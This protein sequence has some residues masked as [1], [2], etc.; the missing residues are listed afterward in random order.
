MP[1]DPADHCMAL[2]READPDRYLANLYLPPAARRAA[3]T[4]HAFDSEIAR[5]PFL[6]SEPLPGE[7]RLQWWRDFLNGRT[8]DAVNHPIASELNYAIVEHDWPR[9]V[10]D[11]TLQARIFDLYNDPMPDL[12]T[13]EGYLGETVSVWF[14]LTALTAGAEDGSD[15]ADAAGHSGVAVGLVRILTA[16]PVDRA[17]HR[18]FLPDETLTQAG[19][20]RE[21][22]FAAGEGGAKLVAEVAGLARG[23]LAGAGRAIEGL[24]PAHRVAFLPLALCEPRLQ[25]LERTG[26][27]ALVQPV[28]ISPLKR[29]L[30][31][32]RA[33]RRGLSSAHKA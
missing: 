24:D 2:V 14:R 25:A 5:V 32:W 21:T 27:K 23:H 26:D 15:L 6:V 20:D 19:L 8:Q 9:Q 18:Q 16:L 22:F 1:D 28:S 10:F 29:Y 17:R 11:D 4:L 33:A 30:T 3:F 31:L 7:V 12:N 13:L